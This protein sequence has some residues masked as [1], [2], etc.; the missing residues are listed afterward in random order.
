MG[1][2]AYKLLSQH[3]P[4]HVFPTLTLPRD[5]V[6]HHFGGFDATCHSF[7]RPLWVSDDVGCAAGYG[8]AASFYTKMWLRAPLTALDLKGV[9]LGWL[10]E[11]LAMPSRRAWHRCLARYLMR[12]RIVAI[13]YSGRE[14]FLPSPALVIGA[15]KTVLAASLQLRR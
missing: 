12:Q 3:M 8:I 10:A 5:C 6:L 13:I 9:N 11:T 14:I 7:D 1:P 15:V 4:L 2:A